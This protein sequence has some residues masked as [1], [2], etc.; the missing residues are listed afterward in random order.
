MSLAGLQGEVLPLR[1]SGKLSEMVQGFLSE[2]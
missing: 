2:G 1:P